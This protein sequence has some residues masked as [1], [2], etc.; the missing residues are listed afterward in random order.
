DP[1]RV[2]VPMT[3]AL[4]APSGEV[5]QQQSTTEANNAAAAG[6]PP[7]E[8]EMTDTVA[9]RSVRAE[10]QKA[11]REELERRD[12]GHQSLAAVVR[13]VRELLGRKETD[14][15]VRSVRAVLE[16]YTEMKAEN[17]KLLAGEMSNRIAGKVAVESLR[18]MVQALVEMEH[19]TTAK[20]LERAMDKV[21]A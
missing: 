11:R 1:A 20:E 18:P 13:E 8:P 7:E 4:P 14:D 6:G 17:S 15:M 5:A 16:Q 10:T 3:A 2:G 19:P 9:A 21:L 12:Q